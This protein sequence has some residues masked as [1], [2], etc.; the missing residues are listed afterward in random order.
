MTAGRPTRTEVEA[1][2]DRLVP[3]AAASGIRDG[4]G[5]PPDRDACIVNLSLYDAD[6]YAECLRF[7][8][9]LDAAIA[10]GLH[11]Q[12]GVI[13]GAGMTPGVVL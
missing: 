9:A 11:P 3:V 6:A 7:A 4:N 13:D 1:L 8:D 2:A 12:L 5:A 10:A